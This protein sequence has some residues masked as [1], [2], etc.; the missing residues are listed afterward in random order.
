MSRKRP[1]YNRYDSEIKTHHRILALAVA[2]IF[3][4]GTVLLSIFSVF[5]EDT[6]AEAAVDP[7]APVCEQQAPDPS[8]G[9]VLLYDAK[10]GQVLYEKNAGKTRT[11][12]S[13]TKIMTCILVLENLEPDQQ[14]TI[15]GK[16][17]FEE[18]SSMEIRE[19][20][21]LTVEQLLYGLMLPSGNDA[22]VALA[23]VTAGSVDDFVKMMNDKAKE[24]G[25]EHTHYLNPNG[26]TD[27]FEHCTTA[28]DQK[29]LIDYALR[30][31]KFRTIVGTAKYTV[32]ATNKSE[33][34]KL[35]NTN[36]LL[37]G[38][39]TNINVMGK[40]RKAKYDGA[41]GIK[42]GTMT[43]AGFCL[44]AGAK[45]EGLDLIFICL[46]GGEDMDRYT[47]AIAMFDWGFANYETAELMAPGTECGKVKVQYAKTPRIRTECPKGVYAT[48]L[49]GGKAINANGE[50]DEEEQATNPP[51][52][53]EIVL[54]EDAKAPLKKGD[55]VG[56][57][58]IFV[59]DVL[60]GRS[61]VTL[62]EDVEEGGP[63]SRWYISD[64]MAYTFMGVLGLLILLLIVRA[65][66]KRRYRRKREA[67]RKA[68]R[69]QRRRRR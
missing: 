15:T 23:V 28:Y 52:R 4:I 63:W 48:V 58:D 45:Q 19:G 13:L 16:M 46:K 61:D 65:V 3:L 44:I 29:L 11:P 50:D 49:K 37:T 64:A 22:A 40:D 21:V 57:V 5:G 12:A 10:T 56:H 62:L 39:K 17:M 68:E 41:Y 1:N 36:L 32:P 54:D 34:R 51:S 59:G 53:Y 60:V 7:K 14:V 67:M 9:T 33:A 66:N 26:Y 30:N 18:G 24:L 2:I 55:T 43:S 35:R 31:E 38:G 69:E 20:E 6:V 25:M 8:S 27:S 42:T 47:D